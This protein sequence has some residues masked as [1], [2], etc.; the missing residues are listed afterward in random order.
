MNLLVFDVFFV[1]ILCVNSCKIILEIRK[2]HCH[3]VC[4]MNPVFIKC[5]ILSKTFEGFD[6]LFIPSDVL[7]CRPNIMV[8][9]L[10]IKYFNQHAYILCRQYVS[11]ICFFVLFSR[12][13]SFINASFC[14][15]QPPFIVL[16]PSY[17]CSSANFW[18][19]CR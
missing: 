17:T 1:S 9:Y 7:W 11:C 19:L 14:F 4:Y 2:I 5:T 10:K 12:L 3:L 6:Q 15:P 13:H 16:S 8:S 18:M